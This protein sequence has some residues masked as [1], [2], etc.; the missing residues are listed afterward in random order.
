MKNGELPAIYKINPLLDSS[1]DQR[2]MERGYFMAQCN[3]GNDTEPV[4]I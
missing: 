3:R 2:L 1:F 4:C